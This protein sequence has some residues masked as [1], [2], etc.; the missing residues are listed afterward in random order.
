[1]LSFLA[2]MFTFRLGLGAG[3]VDGAV[4]SLRSESLAVAAQYAAETQPVTTRHA[5]EVLGSL[6]PPARRALSPRDWEQLLTR[7]IQNESI[8]NAAMWLASQ[9]LHV[10][11]TS[12]KFFVSVRIATP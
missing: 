10:S 4:S 9:P 2:M 11:V 5:A 3:P 6:E 1:M 7:T 12:E 8:A